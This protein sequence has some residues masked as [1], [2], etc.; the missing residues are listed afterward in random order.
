MFLIDNLFKGCQGRSNRPSIMHAVSYFACG[1]NDIHIKICTIL[2]YKD[3][4][5]QK[6]I[7]PSRVIRFRP[8]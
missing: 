3:A 4:L 2:Y 6:R 8:F 1:I 7:L 5:K